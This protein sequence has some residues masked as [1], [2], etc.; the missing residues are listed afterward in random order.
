MSS[1]ACKT[2][3]VKHGARVTYV[4]EKDVIEKDVIEKEVIE[5]DVIEK[6]VIK[7]DV[8]EKDVIEKDVIEKEAD[9][10]LCKKAPITT[11]LDKIK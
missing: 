1:T 3:L 6:D 5:K 2:S 4:I 11:S 9:S 8:I 10:P 7:K